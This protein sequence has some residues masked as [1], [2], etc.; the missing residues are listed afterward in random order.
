M[1]SFAEILE[2]IKGLRVYGGVQN[3]VLPTEMAGHPH[4]YLAACDRL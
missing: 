2:I 1:Q 3:L 4:N